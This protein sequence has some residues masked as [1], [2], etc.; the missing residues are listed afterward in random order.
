M[1][2]KKIFQFNL[3]NFKKKLANSSL[4]LNELI[5]EIGKYFLDA[6]YQTATLE[7][8]H[9]EKLIVNFAQFDCFTFVETVLVLAKCV[10]NGNTTLKD[11]CRQLQLIRY[12]QGIVNGYSSRL[13]YFTDWLKDNVRK[14]NLRDISRKLGATP[15]RKEINYLTVHC[16][17]VAALQNEEEFQKMLLVEERL[18]RKVIYIIPVNEVKPQQI[19]IK[20]GDIIAFASNQIGLDVAHVGF[21]L[22]QDKKL[23]LLHAA[24][25]EGRVVVS[26]KTLESYLRH[27]K[28]FSGIFVARVKNNRC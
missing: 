1:V 15:Q 19:N 2:K 25:R 4:P 14:K 13:H 9:Q 28:R 11:F 7:S 8:G 21:A 17:S 27:N 18:S 24:S 23:H 5:C 6:P 12:R 16:R 20:S 10:E 26:A 3:T 22:R